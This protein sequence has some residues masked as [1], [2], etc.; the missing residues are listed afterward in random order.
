[1]DARRAGVVIHI[2][3]EGDT[4]MTRSIAALTLALA[5]AVAVV[6]GLAIGAFALVAMA[7]MLFALRPVEVG[8]VVAGLARSRFE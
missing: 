4:A 7:W 3:L 6:G 2:S 8:S 5:A 1:M